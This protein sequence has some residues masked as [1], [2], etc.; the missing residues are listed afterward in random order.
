MG[1]LSLQAAQEVYSAHVES[2]GAKTFE[3]LEAITGDFPQQAKRL[4]R[5]QESFKVIMY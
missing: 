4:S 2:N 3:T 5:V 1:D